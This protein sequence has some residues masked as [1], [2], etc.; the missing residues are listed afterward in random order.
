[1]RLGYKDGE[2]VRDVL[3][4][5]DTSEYAASIR[6]RFD[7]IKKAVDVQ[8]VVV[9]DELSELGEKLMDSPLDEGKRCDYATWISA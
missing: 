4:E 2:Y 3:T 5:E 9:P 7:V 8:P 1:M 6:S